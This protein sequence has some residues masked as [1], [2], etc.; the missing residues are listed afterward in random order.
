MTK[1]IALA[2]ADAII[3]ASSKGII[4][5]HAD[6]RHATLSRAAVVRHAPRP[7]GPRADDTNLLE[8]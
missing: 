6:G 7:E 1:P 4:A 8:R 5:S 3:A 2:A